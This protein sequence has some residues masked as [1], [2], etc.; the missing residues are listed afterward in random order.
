MAAAPTFRV[1]ISRR[2][3]CVKLLLLGPYR[4]KHV[5]TALIIEFCLC[6]LHC[7]TQ[8]SHIFNQIHILLHNVQVVL[9]VKGGCL[10]KL[11]VQLLV[12]VGQELS[13]GLEFLLDVLIDV[14]LFL[15]RVGDIVVQV[16]M[17]AQ[18]ELVVI[19]DVLSDPVNSVTVGADVSFVPAD[20]GAG[21]GDRVLHLLLAG[22]VV[23]DG[24]TETG[25]NLIEKLKFSIE[26]VGLFLQL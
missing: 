4:V 19:V 26:L 22:A 12:R 10:L 24:Q 20:L 25:V 17:E 9:P 18:F 11:V 15:L 23:I 21:V 5:L 6:L 16:C 14:L 8:D 1:S 13:L 2:L 7:V 3:S